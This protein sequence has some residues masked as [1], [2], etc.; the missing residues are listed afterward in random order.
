[1]LAG[2]VLSEGCEGDLFLG[3]ASC[4]TTRLAILSLRPHSIF[5]LCV[6][7]FEFL[8]LIRTLVILA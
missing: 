2:L 3:L 8:L 1:M 6:S 7:V 4:L 5:P